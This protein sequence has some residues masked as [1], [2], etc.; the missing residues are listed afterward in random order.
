MH[1]LANPRYLRRP[2]RRLHWLD[3]GGVL[4]AL[5]LLSVVELPALEGWWC[6][7][8]KLLVS[9]PVRFV[10]L[11]FFTTTSRVKVWAPISCG[12][13]RRCHREL[14]FNPLVIVGDQFCKFSDGLELLK[15]A[16]HA[17]EDAMLLQC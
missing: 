7:N 1:L 8:K 17:R 9:T 4:W 2:L 15:T 16:G 13:R 3:P 10:S 5:E 11:S 6:V 14:G 12:V